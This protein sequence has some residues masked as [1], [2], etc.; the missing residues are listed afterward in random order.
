VTNIFDDPEVKAAMA[1]AG[2][3]HK[4]GIAQEVLRD[5]APF[6]AEEGIDLSDPGDANLETLNAALAR[7]TLRHNQSLP[8]FGQVRQ[9]SS[10]RQ[11]AG[12]SPFIRRPSAV[13]P[14]PLGDSDVTAPSHSRMASGRS[15]KRGKHTPGLPK[16]S[17]SDRSLVREFDRWLHRQPEIAA[18]SPADESQYDDLPLG[19]T[20]ASV[21]ALAERLGIAE[22]ATLDQRHF[23]TVRP[24]H[25]RSLVL[26]PETS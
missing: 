3:V 9:G 18:A 1:A 14:L 8:P 25:T 16:L 5:L 6:L 26:L 23:R 7:A 22:I 19:T 21:I 2:V 24:G 17:Q 15:S 20:D 10:G 13:P 4:P 12:G 11:P